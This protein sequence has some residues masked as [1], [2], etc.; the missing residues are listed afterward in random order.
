MRLISAVTRKRIDVGHVSDD[1]NKN[2]RTI[3][4]H[5]HRTGCCTG[6]KNQGN[7]KKY[8]I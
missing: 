1:W 3:K 8:N 5:G 4:L 7:T 2:E 6:K